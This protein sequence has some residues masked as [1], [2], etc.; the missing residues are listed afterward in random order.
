[1]FGVLKKM[2]LLSGEYRKNLIIAYIVSI[3]EAIAEKI[4]I[5]MILYSLIKIVDKS[6]VKSDFWFI[7]S[8][9]IGSLF[10]TVIFRYIRDRNQSGIGVL[11][12]ARERLNLGNRIKK[13]PMA[14][15]TE[16]NIGNLSAVVSSDMKFIEE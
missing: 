14:Y 8:V 12:F 11:I 6:L 1:M 10:I 2:S 5:F 3:F 9:V 7:L 13:F 4:P 15:F 16:G